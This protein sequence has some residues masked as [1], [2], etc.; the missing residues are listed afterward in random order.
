MPDDAERPSAEEIVL[1]E[2]D[3]ATKIATITL[4][5]PGFLNAPTIAARQRYADL[6]LRANV[7]DDV[8]VLVIRGVGEHLGSGADLPEMAGMFNG[9]ESYSPLPEFR[10]D[11]EDTGDGDVK[12]PPRDSY[13][14]IANVTNLYADARFG[15]RSLQDFKKISI[16]EC[17]GYCYGWHFYQAADADIVISS[18]EAL[19]GHSAFRYVGWAARQ[20]Q[21]ATMMGLR[22]FMEMVFTGRPFT[23]KE[24]KDL[25]FVNSVVPR[26]S[27][28]AET[29]KYALACARNRPT[30]TVVMQKTFF[31][32]FKQQQGE[33]MGSVLSGWLEGMLPLV[34]EEG[35]G[36]AVDA[37]TFEKGL[38]AAV[39]D[40]DMQFPPEWRLSYRGRAQKT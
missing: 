15:L 36:I 31:E 14:Y 10:I 6:V 23:A 18:D 13:R 39:K 24:M 32:V 26:D 40:N 5:R 1:Y 19:F 37:D 3:P 35:G 4:S 8:K 34:K 28:E 25:H 17:K 11:G 16:I 7:D 27:L 22:P 12:Y 33:Y 29:M 21:W 20:W 30:D 9:D 2:K 38:A